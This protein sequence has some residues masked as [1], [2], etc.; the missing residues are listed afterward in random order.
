MAKRI[1]HISQNSTHC[2]QMRFLWI[3]L[4][5][6]QQQQFIIIITNSL[7]FVNVCRFILEEIS[8]ESE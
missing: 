6:N 5:K 8:E 1:I 4:K 7:A 2:F 3:L